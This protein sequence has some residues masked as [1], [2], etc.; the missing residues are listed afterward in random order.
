MSKIDL[1]FEFTNNNNKLKEWVCH[2]ARLQGRWKRRHRRV[3]NE[4]RKQELAGKYPESSEI[5]VSIL[6]TGFLY[7]FNE[8][9][10]L[11]LATGIDQRRRI[12]NS[13]TNKNMFFKRR[14]ELKM[15]FSLSKIDFSSLWNRNIKRRRK[16][17]KWNRIFLKNMI[18]GI[19]SRCIIRS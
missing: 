17:D 9:N 4:W 7:C 15:V 16:K 2:P 13:L 19:P 6:L 3:L 14:V 8:N 10:L 18:N 5:Q 11:C 12:S 1:S